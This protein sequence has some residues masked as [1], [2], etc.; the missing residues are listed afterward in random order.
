MAKIQ[1]LVMVCHDALTHGNT[2]AGQEAKTRHRETL[3]QRRW[4]PV[5]G[6]E[7][8]G[9]E[10]VT[11]YMAAYQLAKGGSRA[12]VDSRAGLINKYVGGK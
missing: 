8:C 5:R 3:E 2:D 7:L 11:W 10:S 9:K 4:L 12:W 6:R 1:F